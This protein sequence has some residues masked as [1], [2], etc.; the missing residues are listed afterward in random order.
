[1]PDPQTVYRHKD[2]LWFY[3][4]TEH[5]GGRPKPEHLFVTTRERIVFHHWTETVPAE[6]QLICDEQGRAQAEECKWL[7]AAS[8]HETKIVVDLLKVAVSWLPE[9]RARQL[10]A[11]WKEAQP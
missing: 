4:R 6:A 1:M 8:E 11:A 3:V 7:L 5:R 10:R 9:E 2:E